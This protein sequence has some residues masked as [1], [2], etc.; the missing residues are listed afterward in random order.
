MSARFLGWAVVLTVFI[1]TAAEAQPVIRVTA[2]APEGGFAREFAAGDVVS[3]TLYAQV[4]GDAP[5]FGVDLELATASADLRIASVDFNPALSRAFDREAPRL[6]ASRFRAIRAQSRERLDR[7]LGADG[8]R[9]ELATVEVEVLNDNAFDSALEVGARV[10]LLGRL[11]QRTV[12]LGQSRE[13]PSAAPTR[14]KIRIANTRASA[15]RSGDR[16]A[17]EP[18]A[19]W[20]QREVSLT[21]ELRPIGGGQAVTVLHPDTEYELHYRAGIDQASYYVL[22]AVATS[23]DQGLASVAPPA[24]GDWASTGA[25]QFFDVARD[26]GEVVEAPDFPEG[27]YRTDWATD[28]FWTDLDR[29]VAADGHLCTVTTAGEGEFSLVLYMDWLNLDTASAVTMEASRDFVVQRP[30]G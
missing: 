6:P 7:Q 20:S 30:G 3:V 11:P 15:D 10:G 2:D 1:G 21:F 25:F 12:V 22:G 14:G 17:P 29:R 16:R 13:R 18:E 19:S 27:Y 24:D 23:S 9:I 5:L 28:A 26:F 4:E 8:G